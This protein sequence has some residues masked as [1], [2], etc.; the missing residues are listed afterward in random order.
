[1]D[2]GGVALAGCFLATLCVG[3]MIFGIVLVLRLAVRGAAGVVSGTL[4]SVIPDNGPAYPAAQAQAQRRPPTS[5]ELLEARRQALLNQPLAPGQPQGGF[6][7]QNQPYL[8]PARPAGQVQARSPQQDPLARPPQARPALPQQGQGAQWQQQQPQQPAD[9][10]AAPPPPRPMVPSLS[11]S[12]PVDP[13]AQPPR[14]SSPHPP[15]RSGQTVDP[16]AA[17]PGVPGSPERPPNALPRRGFNV[18]DQPGSS[19]RRG[20]DSRRGDDYE[21][22]A[23]IDGDGIDFP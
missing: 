10:L 13:L 2:L 23:D 16:L 17:P 1:M 12:R 11:P 4:N 9:P 3:L 19:L 20:R 5:R 6:A 18:S 7:A 22:F 14:L 21:Q 15:L 8:S